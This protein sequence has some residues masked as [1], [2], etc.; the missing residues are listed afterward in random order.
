MLSES[1]QALVQEVANELVDPDFPDRKHYNRSLYFEG[2]RGPLC[3]KA[4]R[5]RAAARYRR[6]NPDRKPRAK[7]TWVLLREKYLEEVIRVLGLRT[8]EQARTLARAS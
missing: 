5:D 2:C 3:T 8:E 4:E 6:R 7:S 1:M